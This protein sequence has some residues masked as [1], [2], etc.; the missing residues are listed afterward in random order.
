MMT[1]KPRTLS[2]FALHDFIGCLH[3]TRERLRQD[4]EQSPELT[5][6]LDCYDRLYE[7]AVATQEA[8]EVTA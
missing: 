8:W 2:R 6:L 7:A 4:R 3:V 5:A 1:Y